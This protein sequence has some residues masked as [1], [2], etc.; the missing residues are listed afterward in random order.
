MSG[1]F[2]TEITFRGPKEKQQVFLEV[3]QSFEAFQLIA[4]HR[5]SRR[6]KKIE[7]TA[8]KETMICLDGEIE[9]GERF[10]VEIVPGALRFLVPQGAGY[11]GKPVDMAAEKEAVIKIDC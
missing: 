7:V 9:T 3:L 10:T 1:E 11:T 2:Y 5:N 6:A 8:P 4:K